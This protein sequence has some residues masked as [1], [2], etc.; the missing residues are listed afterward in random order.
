MNLSFHARALD[1][2][3]LER[4]S[5]FQGEVINCPMLWRVKLLRAL[6]KKNI[7]KEPVEWA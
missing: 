7:G 2:F 3:V 5:D 1:D 4:W 6:H